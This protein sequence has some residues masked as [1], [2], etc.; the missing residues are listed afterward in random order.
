MHYAPRNFPVALE[1]D[2][3]P[4]STV[5]YQLLQVMRFAVEEINNST[6]ILPDVSLGYDIFDHCSAIEIFPSVFELLS[7]KGAIEMIPNTDYQPK[8]ISVLGP[9][10][11][12]ESI[13]VAPLFMVQLVAMVNF[14]ASTST[15][16]D[17]V[18]FPSF[19]RTVTSNRDQLFKEIKKSDFTLL[20]HQIKFDKNGDPPSRYNIVFWNLASSSPFQHIGSY[21]TNPTVHLHIN[22]SL[23][24]WHTNGTIPVSRCSEECEKGSARRPYGIFKCCFECDVCPNGTYINTSGRK[25]PLF[26]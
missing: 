9:F 1:C 5:G 22:D 6:S 24:R 23:I 7:N 17:K 8:V 14:G 20:D 2:A 3:L 21:H 19:L 12:S 15:L 11:S 18:A 26:T 25:N 10:G 4:L 16:S 13:T